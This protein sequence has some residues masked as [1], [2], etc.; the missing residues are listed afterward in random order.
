MATVYRRKYTHPLPEGAEQLMQ[1][2]RPKARWIDSHG[3][4]HIEDTT[5]GRDGSPRIVIL[6][7]V[8]TARYRDASGIVR[9]VSTGCRDRQ[10]AEKVLSTLM[11][12]EDKLRAGIYSPAD[13]NGMSSAKLPLAKHIAGYIHHLK[14]K[15]SGDQ[16]CRQRRRDLRKVFEACNFQRL[17]DLKC[18][19]AE[20]WLLQRKQEGMSAR[21]HNGYRASL[22]AFSNWAVQTQR[23]EF[24]PFTRIPV[25]NEKADR[26][27]PRRPLSADELN[28]LLFVAPLRPLA[29]YGRESIAKA[30][31]D[32]TG[33]STWTKQKLDIDTIESAYQR[34]RKVLEDRP[35]MIEQLIQRGKRNTMFYMLAAYT[36]LRKNEL[37][38][39]RLKDIRLDGE[40]PFISLEAR[41]EKARRG[42]QLPLMAEIAQRLR[43]Y[44]K[45]T[46]GR[47]P[48]AGTKLF[49]QTTT[50]RAF[51]RDL[52]AAGIEKVD[53][54][55]RTV[56]IHSLRHT[57][58]TMLARSGVIPQAAQKLMRHSKI[59]L[60]MNLYTH[61]DLADI[62]SAVQGLPSL[63]G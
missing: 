36:G 52:A 46:H 56:D 53:S 26:R 23:M 61:L 30:D 25:A 21:V 9:F 42:A 60:T 15:G 50:L 44:I 29:D 54:E 41:Y 5:V 48:G 1:R 38:N 35:E 20:M 39:V 12:R 58:G 24:N 40:I 4:V 19:P 55:G 37:A 34:A 31:A 63:A 8:Y 49:Q 17:S 57:F 11:E 14:A 47:K 62:S 7:P 13:I 16:H 51:N 22:M 18:E 3:K 10:A 45:Q 59:E 2:G 6:S 27:R 33:R 32:C 28:R 43:D